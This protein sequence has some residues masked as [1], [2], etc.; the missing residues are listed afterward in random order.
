MQPAIYARV[1][2]E[3]QDDMLQLAELEQYCERSKWPAPTIYSDKASGKADTPRPGL[4]RLLKD[5]HMKRMD[6][7]IVWKLDRFGRNLRE[8]LE[9][10]QTL[11]RCGVRFLVPAQGL[12][13]DKD[14]VLGR[15][16]IHI[17]GAVAELERGF[18]SERTMGGFRAYRKAQ[19][20]GG[21]VFERFIATRGRQ[22]KSGANLAVGRPAKVFR[23]DRA[24]KMRAAGK[25][26][27]EIAAALGVPRS[28]VRR[29]LAREDGTERGTEKGD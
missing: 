14:S 10:I 2:T 1:S 17:L 23:R 8:I 28:T 15:F 3:H 7:V 25:S 4:Q 27:N 19:Q 21:A 22:S 24:R 13:T 20:S 9:N 29:E 6:V 11:D 12:D 26:W 5:A 16:F 18:I